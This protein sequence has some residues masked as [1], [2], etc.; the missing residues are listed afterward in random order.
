MSD[1]EWT[2]RFRQIQ[3]GRSL[4][5][6][7][8]EMEEFVAYQRGLYWSGMLAPNRV[9]LL[10]SIDEFSWSHDERSQASKEWDRKISELIQ[11]RKQNGHC[12]VRLHWEY[13]DECGC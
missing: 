12:K 13:G 6:L 7:S 3:N 5:L 2:K 11:F 1:D 4:R 9:E 10:N 8:S